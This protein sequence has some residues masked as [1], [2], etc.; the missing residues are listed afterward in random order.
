MYRSLYIVDYPLYTI[1]YKQIQY[2][3]CIID[4]VL[5]IVDYVSFIIGPLTGLL[6]ETNNSNIRYITK[7]SIVH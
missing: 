5:C 2:L 6:E 3:L 4:V 7:M 1:Y